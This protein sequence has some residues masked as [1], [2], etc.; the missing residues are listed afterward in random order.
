[1]AIA[2]IVIAAMASPKVPQLPNIIAG[3]AEPQRFV[4]LVRLIGRRK[5]LRYRAADGAFG[6]ATSAAL[7]ALGP[8]IDDF[9]GDRHA[10]PCWN[11]AVKIVLG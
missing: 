5:K 4:L 8:G 6:M 7:G 1:M 2:K 3:F 10:Y 11:K 9:S